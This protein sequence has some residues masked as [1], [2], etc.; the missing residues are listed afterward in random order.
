MTW[1]RFLVRPLARQLSARELAI[2]AGEILPEILNRLPRAERTAFLCE[3]AEVVVGP[4]LRDLGREERAQLLNAL[5]PL[6]AREFP[7]SDLDLLA[8]FPASPEHT[9][10]V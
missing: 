2:V 3:M 9:T 4:A 10:E 5:L 1:K 7:L 8:A 6:V